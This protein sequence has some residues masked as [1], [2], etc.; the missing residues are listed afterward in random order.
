MVHKYFHL[1][2][3]QSLVLCDRYFID[4]LADPRR[5]RIKWKQFFIKLYHHLLPQA[6]PM[7]NTGSAF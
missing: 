1:K 2:Q 6:G 4:I 7:D 3:N 5:Y